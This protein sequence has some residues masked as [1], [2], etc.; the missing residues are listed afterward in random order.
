MN[1][2]HWL[3]KLWEAVDGKR[4]EIIAFG[5]ALYKHPETG[6]KE[7]ET[8]RLV[9][10]EWKKVGVTAAALDDIPGIKV[11]VDT[12]RNG[13]GVAVLGELDAV[14]CKEHP[15]CARDTGAVHACGHNVQVAAMLGAAMGLLNS[16]IVEELSGKIHFIAV[17]A[18][19]YIEVAYRTELREKGIIRYL[20]GKPELLHR[21]V[22]DDVDLCMMIHVNPYTSKL[23]IE[24]T[25]N[26]CLVKKIKYMGKASHAGMA[27]H[28]GVN[29]LYAAN[30][31]MM[32]INCLR[33]TFR[34]EDY[35]RV[36]PIVTKGGDIVNAIPEDVRMETFVRGKSMDAILSAARKVDRALVGGAIAMG[37]EV[38]IENTPGYFPL[39]VDS[40]LTSIAGGMARE[41]TGERDTPVIGHSAGSTD[42]GDI[43]TLMPVIEIAV[44]GIEGGLHSA[45]YRNSDHD[46]SYI[47]GAKILAGLAFELLR[48][49]AAAALEVL[50]D[51]SPAFRS[52]QEY[53]D[54][55]D[56][57]F[58]KKVF[59]EKEVM[60][61]FE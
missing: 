10:E 57:L 29:A 59:P 24:S 39:R 52:K 26:G 33:E 28:E 16:G 6:F 22:F 43:S 2:D 25:A 54:Y 23:S 58:A 44:G 35:I 36:H 38:E 30:L 32:A 46:V 41:L 21:G 8:A 49:N 47:L 50:K 19:E 27:P 53:M 20:G 60:D 31:G 9:A 48:N 3:S 11:T 17:P 7:L 37:A 51:Y 15:H 4:E 1:R 56:K 45:D 13:P 55:V 40:K 61:A 12:G 5:E 34:E 42:L 14:I 18:E